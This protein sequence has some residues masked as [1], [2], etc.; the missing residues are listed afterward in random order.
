MGIQLEISIGRVIRL[1]EL[2]EDILV[3]FALP[4]MAVA[5]AGKVKA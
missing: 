5:E 4:I 2:F 1:G 3:V